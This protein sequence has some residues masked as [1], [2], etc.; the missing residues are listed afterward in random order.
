MAVRLP[1]P[2]PGI[3]HDL[4]VQQELACALRILAREGW[5]E[6]LSGHITVATDDGGMW[7]NPWGLWWEEVRASD[8]LRLDADGRIVDGEWD[9]TPAVFLHTE[10]HRARADARV[11][12]HNHP[13]YATLLSTIG[14]Q[15]RLVHQNSCI[16]DGELAF[17][18]EYGGVGD[19]SE[20][21]WL[22]EQVGDA[23]GILLAHHGA[24]VTAPTIPA[25]C[26]KAT[27][28]ER[29]CRLTFDALV[30]GHKPI[31]VPV[32]ARPAL[33]TALQQNTPLAYWDGAV[34]QLLRT[35]PEVL[36]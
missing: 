27:T 10:L 3:G 21:Q 18:D 32:A 12:V 11:I 16:F 28:F 26:Y 5:R 7:C 31:E 35:D 19:A 15:P 6:N 24:I 9:V 1:R 4:T 23:S 36:T 25:A 33:R 30:A 29:M 14:E 20:G 8:I 17:V 22:A 13:Y 34:R 2:G